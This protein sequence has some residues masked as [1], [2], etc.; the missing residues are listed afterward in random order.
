[1]PVAIPFIAAAASYGATTY[2]VTTLGFSAFAGAIIG[3]GAGLA[4]S[5]ALNAAFAPSGPDSRAPDVNSALD[6]VGAGRNQQVRQPT[7]AHE[8]VF[9]RIKKAGIIVFLHSKVDDDGR[10]DGYQY[11]QSVLAAHSCKAIGNIYFS[12]ELASDSKFTGFYQVGKNLGSTVQTEDANFLA[13]LGAPIF[14]NH[15]LRGRAN[16]ATRLKIKAEIFPNGLPNIAAI[17]DG[18]D[19]IYD[20]R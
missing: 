4:T 6:Q 10:A 11:I 3:A 2:A 19:M 17:V 1:M 12:D 8:V 9:G 14:S 15:N 18:N 7:A 20:P 13:Q 5:I 16:I